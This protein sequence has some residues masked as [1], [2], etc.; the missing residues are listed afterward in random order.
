LV[1][2]QGGEYATF[3]GLLFL[4]SM[5][6]HAEHIDIYALTTALSNLY[7]MFHVFI[8]IEITGGCIERCHGGEEM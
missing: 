8:T 5:Q 4:S 7:L 1:W 3:K 6:K 2:D